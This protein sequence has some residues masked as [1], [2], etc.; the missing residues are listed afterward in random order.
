MK[1]IVIISI[2]T[3]SVYANNLN[4]LIDIA[5]K[6]NTN[7]KQSEI[8]VSTQEQSQIKTQ[9]A[10]LPTLNLEADISNHDIET[11]GVTTDG[12]SK[13]VSLSA[14][15]L[16]YDFGKSTHKIKA[17]K[18]NVKASKKELDSTSATIILNVKKVYFDI[19]NKHALI[20]VAQE[21]VKIDKFQLYQAQEYFKAKVKTKIDVTNAQLQLSNSNMKLLK[22]N[23]DLKKA[24]AK[25]ITL[26]GQEDITVNINQKDIKSQAKE[27]SNDMYN[28][29]KLLRDAS[30]NRN[31]LI[32]YT[33]LEKALNSSYQSAKSDFYPSINLIG[34]YKDS[35][36]DDIASLETNQFTTGVYLKWELFSGFRT[37]ASK[38]EA[39][40]ELQNIKEKQK[41]QKLSII[42]NVTNAYFNVEQNKQSVD[43]SLL[44]IELSQQNLE[45]AQARYKNG[46]NSLVELN[47]AKLDFITANNDLVNQYYAYKISQVTLEYETGIDTLSNMKNKRN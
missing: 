33:H 9:S 35:H 6:N 41:E 47:D 13:T 28:L 23:F 15:Q 31:E 2:L 46:L 32:M 7:I 36:S 16:L 39:L 25:L 24:N 34:S 14:S 3:I 43:I 17:T 5:L 30:E 11:S 44:N 21:S 37:S 12:N 26:L 45:L 19:L 4:D 27:I 38:K 22:A 29:E 40:N 20:K 10:F 8:K 18:E 1:K 42:E